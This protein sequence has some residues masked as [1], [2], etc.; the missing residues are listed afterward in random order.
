MY[1]GNVVTINNIDIN[2][3][4][5]SNLDTIVNLINAET[6]NHY[7]Q[8]S[9]ALAPTEAAANTSQLYYGLAGGFPPFSAY[10]DTGGSNTLVNFTSVGSD[11]AG[12]STPPD[13]KIDIDAANIPNLEAVVEN[14]ALILKELSGNSITITNVVNDTNSI[15]FAGTSSITGIPNF[16]AGSSSNRLVLTRDDGGEV[17]IYEFSD[18][19]QTTTGIFSGHTGSL[20][21][22]MNIEQG[23]YNGG[24]F[25]VA[26][27]PARDGLNPIVGD[28]A[29]VI[30]SLDSEWALFQYTGSG[31]VELANNDSADTDAR[32]LTGTFLFPIVGGNTTVQNLGNMSPGRKVVEVT[33]EVL[34]PLSN[35]SATPSLS[36]GFSGN[37]NAFMSDNALD[38]LTA[39]QYQVSSEYIYP[40]SNTDDLIISAYLTHNGATQGDIIVRVTY[41]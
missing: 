4:T 23:V 6:A 13:M 17:L 22:A 8:A 12:V 16:T 25:V 2:F 27:I 10:I 3:T 38:L 14:N 29:Y 7:V 26:D 32:T 41:V 35:F 36:I 9:S 24:I 18:I 5:D 11:Y 31:W 30:S 1:A 33:V 19:F 28:Q 34:T 37:I 39:G 21:L 40:E 20:P 15:P